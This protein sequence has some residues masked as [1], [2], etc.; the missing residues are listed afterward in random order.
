MVVLI[1]ESRWTTNSNINS[2]TNTSNDCWVKEKFQIVEE[3][4]PCTNFEVA[5]KSVEACL[6]TKYKEV[7]QCEFTGKVQRRLVAFGC[8]YDLC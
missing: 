4:H 1:V 6:N 2:L 7:L 3:C 5:S 8:V